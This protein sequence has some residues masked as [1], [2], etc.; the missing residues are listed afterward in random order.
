[1]KLAS[2]SAFAAATLVAA[3]SAQLS[4]T[5]LSVNPATY[6]M[7]VVLAPSAVGIY[8]V[9]SLWNQSEQVPTNVTNPVLPVLGV[10]VTTTQD[11]YCRAWYTRAFGGRL[12][13]AHRWGNVR[14]WDA[15]PANINGPLPILTSTPTTYSHE[16]L[17]TAPLPGSNLEYCFYSEQ[18]TSATTAGGLRIYQV[19]PASLTPLGTVLTLGAAGNGLEVSRGTDVVWQWGDQLNNNLNGCLRT[20]DTFNK[21]V[22]VEM[23]RV[24]FPYT[25]G[26]ADKYLEKN[27]S[28][29][30]LVGT[31]GDDGLATFDITAPLAPTIG[32]TVS[33]PGVHLRG[34]TFIPATDFGL[35]WGVVTI[36]TTQLDFMWFFHAPTATIGFTAI[37]S[38]IWTPGFQI[39]DIKIDFGHIYA[40]GRDR[41]TLDSQL[42][43][44]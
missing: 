42:K 40:V 30:A 11:Q 25:V 38:P 34:V 31:L 41:T 1:M 5:T 8:A 26:F 36:G 27:M 10:P 33:A 28:H 32:F 22:P 44:W 37:G 20:Y 12:L 18:H 24:P 3:A 39:M 4:T 15:T 43:I 13:T 16:G 17:K 35:I 21:L 19:N 23:P 29:N 2:R 14:M 6:P 7:S 9:S